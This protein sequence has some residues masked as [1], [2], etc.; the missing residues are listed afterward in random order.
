M[1]VSVS[2][3]AKVNTE[4]L[5]LR[6]TLTADV[7]GQTYS[8]S[9]VVVTQTRDVVGGSVSGGYKKHAPYVD[10]GPEGIVF[11]PRVGDADPQNGFGRYIHAAYGP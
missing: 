1:A 7:G 9:T 6:I 8:N 2:G 3:C 10:L 4:T 5:T 11:C